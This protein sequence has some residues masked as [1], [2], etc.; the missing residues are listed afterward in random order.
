MNNPMNINLRESVRLLNNEFQEMKKKYENDLQKLKDKYKEHLD[1]LN[2]TW[3]IMHQQHQTSQQMLTVINNNMK[4]VI[5]VTCL[6]TTRTIYEALNKITTN[7]N[8][9]IH[10]LENQIEYLQE[11]E[12]FFTTHINSLQQLVDKQN[13]ILNKALDSLFKDPNV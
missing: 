6:K 12:S 13:E 11:A 3:L 2:Q 9:A 10:Q 4:Q 5:F 1:T 7:N 8:E